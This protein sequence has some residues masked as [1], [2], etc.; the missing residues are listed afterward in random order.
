MQ[1]AQTL[2]E[3]LTKKKLKV[4]TAES[5]TGGLLAGAITDISGSSVVFEEGF[6]TYSNAAKSALL[7]VDAKLIAAHGAVSEAVARAMAEGV[8]QKTGA[9]LAVA[10]T[11]IAGPT[12][13]NAEKPVGLVFI[14]TSA[15]D[16]TLCSKNL[17]SGSRS[18]IRQSA[19]DKA[20]HQLLEM[21]G[22]KAN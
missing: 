16:E 1:K 17:F 9:D 11:G 7:G 19:V 15:L 4:T 6:I 14:A 18:A 10:V 22:K 12:G 20:L 3:T 8:R 13:G 21:V 5:C 2:V